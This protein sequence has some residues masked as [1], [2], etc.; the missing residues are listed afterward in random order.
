MFHEY[1]QKI[2][3]DGELSAAIF[4]GFAF[5]DAAINRILSRLS[6][7]TLTF[8]ITKPDITPLPPE[9]RP[10]RAPLT[11]HFRHLCGGLTAETVEICLGEVAASMRRSY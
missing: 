4:I 10:P 8:F 6:L 7:K 9:K 2:V 11:E 1:L 3:E 5:R